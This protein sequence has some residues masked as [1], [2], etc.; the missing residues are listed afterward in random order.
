MMVG[1]VETAPRFGHAY[2]SGCGGV[3]QCTAS[4]QVVV[5]RSPAHAFRPGAR[6]KRAAPGRNESFDEACDQLQLPTEPT[7]QVFSPSVQRASSKNAALALKLAPGI[8]A[9]V[10]IARVKLP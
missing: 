8:L 6:T 3:R 7:S 5:A 9:F 1:G 10:K 2:G 4:I